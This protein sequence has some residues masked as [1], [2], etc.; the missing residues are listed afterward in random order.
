V[1]YAAGDGATRPDLNA[2]FTNRFVGNV[3][4]AADELATA[5]KS[6]APFRKYLN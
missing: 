5:E 4:L 2:L 1:K 6:A 3:V